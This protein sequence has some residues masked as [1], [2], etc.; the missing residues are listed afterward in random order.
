M[1]S[2]CSVRF[3]PFSPD[4]TF[5]RTQPWRSSWPTEVSRSA[6]WSTGKSRVYPSILY[7]LFFFFWTASVM[8]NFPDQATVKKVVNSLP[9]VGVGT[10]YGLPQARWDT[11][12]DPVTLI[13]MCNIVIPLWQSATGPLCSLACSTPIWNLIA[14][15]TE[16]AVTL[17]EPTYFSGRRLYRA[18]LWPGQW[19]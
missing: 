9:R 17:T 6:H 3:G 19:P 15:V 5:C 8:F 4:V 2:G 12:V 16:C 7:I 14:M 18:R 13:N 10:S 1:G 11:P